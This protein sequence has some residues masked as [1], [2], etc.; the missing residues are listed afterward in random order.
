MAGGAEFV[1]GFLN[2]GGFRG[3]GDDG[4]VLAPDG[5]EAG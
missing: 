2:D 4:N 5:E 3:G 1:D